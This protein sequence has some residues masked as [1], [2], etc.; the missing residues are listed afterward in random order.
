MVMGECISASKCWSSLRGGLSK[1][2]ALNRGT[3]LQFTCIIMYNYYTCTY[4]RD[5][6]CK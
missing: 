5:V 2:G 1:E 6:E 4:V 3:T